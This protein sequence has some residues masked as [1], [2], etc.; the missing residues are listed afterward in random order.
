MMEEAEDNGKTLESGYHKLNYYSSFI[1][2]PTHDEIERE[3]QQE[4]QKLSVQEA[5]YKMMR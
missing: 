5:T 4:R 3:F 2:S 1:G